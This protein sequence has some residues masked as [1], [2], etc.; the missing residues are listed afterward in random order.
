[1][2]TKLSE[3]ILHVGDENVLVQSV[4]ECSIGVRERKGSTEITIGTHA[5]TVRDV[6]FPKDAKMRG[7]LIWLPVDKLPENL[8]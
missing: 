3:L 5:V 2:A 8:R 7:M 1:M 6:M 4:S